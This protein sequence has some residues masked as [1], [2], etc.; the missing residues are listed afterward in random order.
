MDPFTP[1][2]LIRALRESGQFSAEKLAVLDTLSEAVLRDPVQLADFLYK[3]KLLTAYQTRK[4]RL[5]RLSEILFGQYLVLDKIGEG[6][7]GKVFKAIQS[8][9]GRIVALKVVRAHLM[10]N[11]T[12]VGRYKRE[13]A[14]AA[15]LNHPNI[16]SLLDADEAQGRYF[17]AME[18]VYGSD[19]ARMVKEFGPLPFPEAAEYIRQGAL[20]LQHS[21]DHGL[22]HRD[23]K[24]SNMLVSGERALPDTGGVAVVRILDMGLVRSLLEEAEA[25]KTE[26]TRD[27]TVVGT[28]DY[29]S[30]EQAKNSSTVDHR[31][32][33]YSLGC[34][35]YY[36]LSGKPPFPDGTPIDKLLRHQLDPPPDLRKQRP[37]VP[38]EMLRAMYKMLAKRPEDRIPSTAEVAR[39]LS[40]FTA[41]GLANTPEISFA[42]PDQKP[43]SSSPVIPNGDTVPNVAV[44]ILE[45]EVVTHRPAVRP[46]VVPTKAKV[47]LV[48]REV[49]SNE[50]LQYSPGSNRRKDNSDEME[51]VEQSRAR[52]RTNEASIAR[53]KRQARARLANRKKKNT[54]NWLPLVFGAAG[55][56]LLVVVGVIIFRPR[57]DVKDPVEKKPTVETKPEVVKAGLPPVWM[58]IPDQAAAVFVVHPEGFWPLAKSQITAQSRMAKILNDLSTKY[59]FDLTVG[60]RYTVAFSQGRSISYAATVEGSFVTD[61]WRST[62]IKQTGVKPTKLNDAEKLVY[63]QSKENGTLGL[64]RGSQNGY[65][66]TNDEA[67]LID[68]SQRSRRGKPII[69]EALLNALPDSNQPDRPFLTFAATGSWNLPGDLSLSEL[70][71]E[72][73]QIKVRL[74]DHAF[75]VEVEVIGKSRERVQDF[76]NIRLWNAVN[77]NY[78]SVKPFLQAI[79]ENT[80]NDGWDRV[81]NF[82]RLRKVESGVWAV[83]ALMTWMERLLPN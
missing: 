3:A 46:A 17:M 58:N 77:S 10:A 70:G 55:L 64:L 48:P 67:F 2:Q 79:T 78:P 83:P 74:V 26:L 49:E 4:V 9:T 75:V 27:G 12:V 36:L 20:G 82:H 69:A 24:P 38:E 23:I 39:I 34:T 16:V 31:A 13:A 18:F 43:V 61:D 62:A 11:K 7:M 59:R 60:E 37:D 54:V 45:A 22:I 51:T 6:G 72:W 81:G 76:V 8:K 40:Q 53:Q 50:S 21:H 41:E 44:K 5:N 29:M 15:K 65:S 73:I 35:L 25:D 71:A 57:S 28:P 19:L 80:T 66:L 30:P 63:G 47:K 52:T 1:E 33:I 42:M 32:D 68:L 56:L 14:A